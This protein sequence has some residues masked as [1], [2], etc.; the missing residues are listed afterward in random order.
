M[1][2]IWE[3]PPAKTTGK[4]GAWF[5][6]YVSILKDNPGQWGKLPLM[7]G[8]NGYS[9]TVQTTLRKNFPHVEFTARPVVGQPNRIDVWGKYPE[10]TEEPSLRSVGRMERVAALT[11]QAKNGK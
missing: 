7:E 8:V 4:Y 5:A 10:A 2:V 1:E 11:A 3:E 9:N 6:E